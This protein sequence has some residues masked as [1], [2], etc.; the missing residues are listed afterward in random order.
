[1]IGMIPRFIP[2]L[3]KVWNSSETALGDEVEP[4][5]G[6]FVAAAGKLTGADGGH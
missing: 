1:M 2:T 4:R 3:T 6:G 5:L